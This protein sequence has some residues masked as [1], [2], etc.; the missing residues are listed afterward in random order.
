MNRSEAFSSVNRYDYQTPYRGDPTTV[1]ELAAREG[2]DQITFTEIVPGVYADRTKNPLQP[3]IDPETEEPKVN[4]ETGEVIMARQ[5][6]TDKDTGGTI[7]DYDKKQVTLPDGYVVDLNQYSGLFNDTKKY[8]LSPSHIGEFALS[9]PI[10]GNRL[11]F[12]FD[13]QGPAR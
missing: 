12:S 10:W 2:D 6:Y 4:E 3:V 9:G 7:I 11:T 5:P 1:A 13:S 8:D